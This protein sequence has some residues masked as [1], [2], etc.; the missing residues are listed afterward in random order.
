VSETLSSA[1]AKRVGAIRRDLLWIADRW[2]DVHES[3]IKG[4][5][6]PW[7][8]PTLTPDAREE[9]DRRARAEK[10]EA[11]DRMPGESI[12]PVHIDVLDTLADILMRADMLHDHV[13]N[14]LGVERLDSA[15]SAFADP[16][17]YLMFVSDH[18][19]EFV[20]DDPD[21][22][23]A[24]SDL[25]RELRSEMARVLGEVFDGQTLAAMCPFCGGKDDHH[26]VGGARTLRVKLIWMPTATDREATEPAII[27]AGGRCDPPE[28][29]CGRRLKGMPVW[30]LAEWEWFA[31]RLQQRDAS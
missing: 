8:E 6:R 16:S 28:S 27:C 31:A 25:A 9:L 18:L 22:M 1:Y 10:A 26:P 7:R 4:T 2:A 29:D 13:A 14:T 20:E 12:A 17:P 30:P 5:K 24:A 21:G 23:D 15:S 19:L 3:R 11:D